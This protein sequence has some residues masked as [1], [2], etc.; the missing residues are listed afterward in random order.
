MTH[1]CTAWG[2]LQHVLC[3]PRTSLR[4]L[5]FTALWV[6]FGDFLFQ[7]PRWFSK[8]DGSC[9]AHRSEPLLWHW[10][11]AR[12][13]KVT[14]QHGRIQ[15]ILCPAFRAIARSCPGDIGSYRI[16]NVY[17]STTEQFTVCWLLTMS[18]LW[19]RRVVHQPPSLHGLIDSHHSIFVTAFT[20]LFSAIGWKPGF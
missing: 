6:G 20:A 11:W 15:T 17:S 7:W 9:V 1:K 3:H 18:R 8:P 12:G 14:W 19:R 5:C 2:F 10:S 13:V 4:T 16:V